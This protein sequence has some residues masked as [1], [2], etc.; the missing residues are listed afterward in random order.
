MTKL[1]VSLLM[2][3][4]LAATTWAA[5][6]MMARIRA[7]EPLIGTFPPNIRPAEA[8]ATKKRYEGLKS[9]LDTRIAAHP[10]D[11]ESLYMRGYLQGMGHNFD[12]PGAWQGATD[13]LQAVLRANPGH[14]A[15]MTALATLWVN[16]NPALA[17]EAEK[18]FRNAQCRQ[19]REPVEEAQRGLFFAFYYQGKMREAL[20]QSEYL[21]QTWPDNEQYRRYNETIR[22]VLLRAE[23]YQA[24][25][26]G[27]V[28]MA[29]CDK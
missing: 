10:Q 29:A 4:L 6:P 22:A 17:P 19:G 2:V 26:P 11:L 28:D 7:L 24:P 20:R 12:Y 18:L 13:D 8:K 1:F 27:K 23:D 25:P 16:S 14:I 9:E 21:L 15:A 3:L 5:D